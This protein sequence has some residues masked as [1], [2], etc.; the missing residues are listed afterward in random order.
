MSLTHI[1]YMH[2]HTYTHIFATNQDG[3]RVASGP[4][5]CV[6]VCVCVCVPQTQFICAHFTYAR[7]IYTHTHTH[8]Y[9]HLQRLK[10]TSVLLAHLPLG[11]YTMTLQ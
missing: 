3:C 1:L 10:V 9:T 7:T 4:C 2:T 6:R 8:T 11:A 5:A